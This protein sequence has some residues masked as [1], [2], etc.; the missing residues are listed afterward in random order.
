MNTTN[1]SYM[2]ISVY[3]KAIANAMPIN[4]KNKS[5]KKTFLSQT[6]LKKIYRLYMGMIPS[7]P[8]RQSLVKIRQ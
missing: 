7:Q 2:N 1:R 4:V 6:S 5:I 8:F 3:E